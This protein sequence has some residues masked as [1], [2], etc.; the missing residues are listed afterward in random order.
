MASNKNKI[1]KVK[2]CTILEI[3]ETQA[4]TSILTL[5]NV[6]LQCLS[7]ITYRENSPPFITRRLS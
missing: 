7:L 5:N 3:M 1:I 2:L 4:L 6:I